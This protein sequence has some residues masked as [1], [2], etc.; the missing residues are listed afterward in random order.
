MSLISPAITTPPISVTLPESSS[1]PLID[2]TISHS[3]DDDDNKSQ[4]I[5]KTRQQRCMKKS[6]KKIKRT[7]PKADSPPLSVPPSI[8]NKEPNGPGRPKSP[9]KKVEISPE[10]DHKST[11]N[12]NKMGKRLSEMVSIFNKYLILNT[13]LNG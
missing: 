8:N 2:P 5:K 6:N 11:N 7:L 4:K 9:V 13:I 10:S 12:D 3:S 1:S